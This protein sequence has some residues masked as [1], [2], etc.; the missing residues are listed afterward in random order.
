M[1]QLRY[2][3]Y[4]TNTVPFYVHNFSLCMYFLLFNSGLFYFSSWNFSR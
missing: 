2:F 1:P 3:Y 4:E